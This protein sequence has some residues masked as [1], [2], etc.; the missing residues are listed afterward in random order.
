MKRSRNLGTKG[1]VKTTCGLIALSM[2]FAGC[3]AAPASGPS[4]ETV[5]QRSIDQFVTH[6]ADQNTEEL[7]KMFAEDGIRVVSG[8][9]LP[10]TGRDAIAKTFAAGF[11]DRD[12]DGASLSG[13]VLAA[14][15]LED[16]MVMAYGTW[17]ISDNEGAVALD[18]KW[19]NVWRVKDGHAHL[20]M[21]SAHANIAED[22]DRGVYA[23]MARQDAPAYVSDGSA[24]AKAVQESVD[25]YIAGV[26]G[27]EPEKVANEFTENGIQLVSSRRELSSGRAAIRDAVRADL[28]AGAPF[29]KTTLKADVCGVRQISPNYVIAHGVWESKGQDGTV[30]TFGQWGNVW[31]IQADGS[32]K[33]LMESAGGHVAL[34]R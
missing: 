17:Q 33:L 12:L 22:F 18:G 8:E 30:V 1:P 26:D 14:R 3:T 20:V 27:N 19:G 13:E 28:A 24:V 34:A 11:S 29:E 9:Q 21:E 15:A 6:W 7:S 25:R 23:S 5:I 32:V 4:L 10:A 31:Q 2:M 16:D